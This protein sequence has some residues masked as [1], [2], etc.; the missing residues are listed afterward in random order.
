M[1]SIKKIYLL[2]AL[3]LTIAAPV[4]RADD[5]TDK[6]IHQAV[7]T[8]LAKIKDPAKELTTVLDEIKIEILEI[9]KN[10]SD[11]KKYSSLK[12]ALEKLDSK[13]LICMMIHLKIV[14]NN[15]PTQTKALILTKVPSN[16]QS[17]FKS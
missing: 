9:I 11:T 17:Y 6:A 10:S 8:K 2:S 7:E 15:I 5:A 12:T 4:L 13:Q 1:K 16:Y 3:A 14:L